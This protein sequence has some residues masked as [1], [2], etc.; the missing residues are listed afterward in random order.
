LRWENGK[1]ERGERDGRLG[2]DEWRLG[3]RH[4]EFRYTL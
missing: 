1:R 3:H 2:T 4:P